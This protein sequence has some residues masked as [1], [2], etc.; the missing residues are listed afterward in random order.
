LPLRLR[1]P[2]PSSTNVAGAGSPVK[3]AQRYQDFAI[4][5]GLTDTEADEVVQETAI[6][7][8]RHLPKYRYDPDQDGDHQP[9]ARPM[10]TEPAIVTPKR[11][12]AGHTTR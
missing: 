3:E 6:A 9:R 7:M 1:N 5:A 11:S 12:T 4:Q 10:A 8:A 2:A